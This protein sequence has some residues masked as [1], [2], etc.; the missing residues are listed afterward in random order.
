M[1]APRRLFFGVV[2]FRRVDVGGR[3]GWNARIRLSIAVTGELGE[4]GESGGLRLVGS[5]EM[6]GRGRG[7]LACNGLGSHLGQ[8]ND[9]AGVLTK[10]DSLGVG[11][12]RVFGHGRGGHAYIPDT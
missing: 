10:Y 12:C 9:V 4:I 5:T 11:I 7:M 8:S 1:S 2:S 6:L 3:G